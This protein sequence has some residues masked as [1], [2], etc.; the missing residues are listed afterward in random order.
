[1][2]FTPLLATTNEIGLFAKGTFASDFD[3][4]SEQFVNYVAIIHE[5]A[6]AQIL[7]YINRVDL[8]AADLTAAPQMYATLKYATIMLI[9]NGFVNWKTKRSGQIIS[10]GEC[11]IALY[12]PAVFTKEVKEMLQP[13]C[14][15]VARAITPD[16]AADTFYS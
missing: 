10:V 4:T 13:Y 16:S 1:M 15:R 2:S 6:E 9:V 14:V 3:I 11:Q 7:T 8:E 12:S 5:A